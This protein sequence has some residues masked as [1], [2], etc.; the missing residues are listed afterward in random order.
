MSQARADDLYVGTPDGPTIWISGS[1]VGTIYGAAGDFQNSTLNGN[2][3]PWL[4]C[5]DVLHTVSPPG[6]FPSASVSSTGVVNGSTV[7]NANEIA[8]VLLHY[9]SNL[10]NQGAVQAAIWK[11][12]YGGSINY[13]SGDGTLS[14]A[15]TYVSAAQSYSGPSLVS[16]LDWLTLTS[17]CQT[18]GLVADPPSVAVPEPSTLAIAGLAGLGMLLYARK[19]HEPL[20]IQMAPC[21]HKDR[22]GRL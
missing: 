11:L 10:S 17:N 8:Y 4:Y 20:I 16:Q 18:Q 6:H 2:A 9:G 15:S 22:T 12:E 19:R 5:V 14:D 21:Q 3:L 7:N 13:I 1:S